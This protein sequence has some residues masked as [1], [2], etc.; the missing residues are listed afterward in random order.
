MDRILRVCQPSEPE[1]DQWTDLYQILGKLTNQ[2]EK[3]MKFAGRNRRPKVSKYIK[4]IHNGVSLEEPLFIR[5]LQGHSGKHL[6]IS[7]FSH[8]KIEK[9]HAPFLYHIGFS[10]NE[11]SVNSGELVPGGCGTS[12]GRTAAYFSLV[13]PLDQNSDP[14]C[15]SYIHIKNHH[16]FSFV[17]DLEAV[18]NSLEFYQT[19]NGSVVCYDTVPAEFLTKVINIKGGSARFGKEEEEESVTNEKNRRDTNKD[20]EM[21]EM[22]RLG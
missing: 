12:T 3:D 9:G 15:K 2:R 16:V 4:K 18:Q 8:K 5:A 1:H 22:G 20:Q 10:R 19:T 17:I 11:D 7:T 13:S 6:D 14:K 21:L